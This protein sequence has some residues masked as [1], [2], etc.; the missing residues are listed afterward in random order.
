MV[1]RTAALMAGLTA[2][3]AL[4]F[5]ALPAAAATTPSDSTCVVPAVCHALA[6]VD[7]VSRQVDAL[8]AA[9]LVPQA[10]AAAVHK[11][12]ETVKNSI[13]DVR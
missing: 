7:A 11:G 8:A 9:G 10:A 12:H 3:L 6:Q 4:A 5:G 1:V 13:R 2:L